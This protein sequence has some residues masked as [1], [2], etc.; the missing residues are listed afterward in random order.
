VAAAGGAIETVAGNGQATASG[1][2]GAATAAG[3]GAPSGVAVD[4]SGDPLFISG[5]DANSVRIV[6]FG[7]RPPTPRFTPT[8]IPTPQSNVAVSGEITYYAN[9]QVRV[10]GAQVALTGAQ[11]Q[12]AV[13]NSSGNYSAAVPSGNRRIE[14]AKTGDVG[15]AVS[16][17]DAVRVLQVITG[18]ESFTPL[19]QLACDATGDGSLSVLDAV[20]ILQLSAGEINRLPVGQTCGSDWLFYPRPDTAPNQSVTIPSISTGSC[21]RGSIALNPL[22]APVAH[23]DFEAIL[24]GDCTGNWNQSG[25]ALRAFASAG[26]TVRLGAMRRAPGRR[27]RLPI[28]VRRSSFQALDIKI[29]YDERALTL[30]S[31]RPHGGANGALISVGTDQPNVIGVSVARLAPIDGSAG[32]MLILEFDKASGR[33]E[34]PAAQLLS[35]QVDEQTDR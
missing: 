17:L 24:L 6:D 31:V 5:K 26:G 2:G 11:S 14:P 25:A 15:S 23:Q 20:R 19:Q 18:E 1:D 4:P 16:A 28:Y 8:P 27:A 10:A 12:T 3:L 9:A 13:T 32:A 30:R 33:A 21:R 35:A 7:G 22:L 29:G 34:D